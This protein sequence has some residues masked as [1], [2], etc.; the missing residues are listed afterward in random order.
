MFA[1]FI[2]EDQPDN[3]VI[4]LA[5]RH[6]FIVWIVPGREIENGKSVR[7]VAHTRQG[8]SRVLLRPAGVKIAGMNFNGLRSVQHGPETDP[9]MANLLVSTCIY[10]ILK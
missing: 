10:R 6:D 8:S 4:L 9:F 7:Q 5:E 2:R 1:P 3:R